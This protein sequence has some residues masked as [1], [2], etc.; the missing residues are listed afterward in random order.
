MLLLDLLVKKGTPADRAGDCGLQWVQTRLPEPRGLVFIPPLIGG[1][2]AQQLNTFRWLVKNGLDLFSF[3]YSGHGGSAGKFSLGSSV[4]D[5]RRM[6]TVATARAGKSGIPLY[7]IAACYATIPL[8]YGALESGEPFKKIVLINPLTSLSRGVLIRSV[9]HFCKTGFDLRRPV[10][11]IKKSIDRYLESLFPG[12][13]RNLAG[14]GTLSRKRTRVL[15]I[16]AEWLFSDVNLNFSLQQTPALCV[17]GRQDPILTLGGDDFRKTSLTCIREV[18]S[19]VTF[20]AINS[21]HFLSD[22]ES[23][24]MTRRAIRSFLL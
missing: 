21:D 13:T 2:P 22:P 14:F 10:L 20:R 18:C 5:T 23:R 9:Y 15:R 24:A 1:S 8:L 3:H 12:I 7:G 6:L 19:K 17:Y 16:L 11:S 4:D